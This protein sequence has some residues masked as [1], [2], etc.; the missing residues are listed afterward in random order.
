MKKYLFLMLLLVLALSF[1]ACEKKEEV[2][3]ENVEKE[4]VKKELTAEEK[5]AEEEAKKKAEEEA[6]KR[7]EEEAKRKFEE[8]RKSVFYM[9]EGSKFYES[10]AFVEEGAASAPP[11]AKIKVVAE[12]WKEVA[13]ETQ[14]ESAEEPTEADGEE[15]SEESAE[16]GSEVGEETEKQDDKTSLGT[17]KETKSEDAPKTL[18]KLVGYEIS[19]VNDTARKAYV[20]AEDLVKYPYDFIE[21]PVEG[22]SYEPFPKKTY[23]NNPPVKVRGVYVTRTSAA[24]GDGLLDYLLVLAKTTDIN[25]FVIDVK[26]DNGLLLFKTKAAEKYMPEENERVVIDDIKAFVKRLKDENIYLVARIVTFKSPLYAQKHPERSLKYKD[27]RGLYSD[28]DGIYWSTPYGRE[29]WDY[30]ISIAEEAADA[31]FNEIQFDYVRFPATTEEEDQILEFYNEKNESKSLVIS[32]FL[33]EAYRRLS[34]KEVYVTADLFG[35]MASAVDDQNIGQHWES[36][37]NYVDYI[38]PMM[39][40]SHYGYNNFGLAVPDAHPYECIDASIKDAISR[41]QNLYTPAKLRPWIQDFTA[42]WVDGYILYG[43]NE[44]LAQIKALKDNGIDEYM[45]WN[46]GNNYSDGALHGDKKN[47]QQ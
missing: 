41:N 29:L 17:D 4:E 15:G 25:T 5:A 47:Q 2:A 43:E 8:E 19:S 6:K 21:Y 35:W 16:Q 27:G 45:L 28:D 44:V 18:K 33:Q 46:A 30:N 37:A 39:Y 10:D 20:K 38:A 9:V 23:E 22:V 36:L 13:E 12:V 1:S 42:P 7:A 32:Q 24:N 3:G 26:D 11:K 14:E 31:G 34:Q 40:P